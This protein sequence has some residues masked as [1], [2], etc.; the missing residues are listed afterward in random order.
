MDRY[1]AIGT[2]GEGGMGR[3][4]RVWDGDLMRELAMKRLRPELRGSARMVRQF[5]WEARVTAYL[6]HPN[7][8][9]LH[10]L[11]LT[12]EGH[13]YFTMKRVRGTSM[14]AT[15]A[16][17]SGGDADLARRFGSKRRLRVFMQLCDAIA[18]AHARG[19]LHRDLK[20]GNVM[21]GE[22]GEVL[23]MDWGL[24]LP[25]P[26]RAG[27]RLRAVRPDGVGDE[28]SSGTPLYMSPEQARGEALDER[29]DVYTL[30]VILYELAALRSPYEAHTVAEVL[31]KVQRAEVRPLRLASPGALGSLVAVVERAMARD[32][33]RR[34]ATVASLRD[35]VEKVLEGRTPAA[36]D[37]PLVARAARFYVARSKILARLRM[38][39]FELFMFG[40]FLGGAFTGAG[41]SDR[42]RSRAAWVL[43]ATVIVMV[44]PAIQ[45]VRAA[46]AD[47][48]RES[49]PPDA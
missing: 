10:D 4:D 27:E 6:D 47:P 5:L 46:R 41:V 18:F 2:L 1:S 19:V 12:P 36:E 30:G 15:I 44:R 28:T 9:P 8:V 16:A 22:H 20:P 42:V 33:A 7:I 21:L 14:E 13:L 37:A 26:G 49:S 31:A 45:W 25:L 23:V 48:D 38:I 39:D 29:S 43:A 11:G 17:L 32:P 3:V 40:S 35:D 24:A 34:Y